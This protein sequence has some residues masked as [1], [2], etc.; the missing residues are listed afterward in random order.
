MKQRNSERVFWIKAI[1]FSY[2]GH[3]PRVNRTSGENRVFSEFFERGHT[4]RQL[5]EGRRS[6]YDVVM[7]KRPGVVA[8]IGLVLPFLLLGACKPK[9]K[10]KPVTV[11]VLRNLRSLYG[12]EFDSR[13][14]EF[15]GNNPRLSSGQPIVIETT[16]GD[17][18]ELLAK[19]SNTG[20]SYDLIILDSPDD[21]SASTALQEDMPHAVNICAGLKACPANVP[22][23]IPPQITG[24]QQE[25]ALIFQ[26]ALQ[27]AP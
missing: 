8:V 15:Q 17:Y 1:N 11:H 3:P 4:I 6:R 2:H 27:K 24:P 13:M 25:A 9:A 18:K 20:D 7:T 16:T 10:V 14:L 12:S 23:I 26:N 5:G 21:A 19:V 22:S